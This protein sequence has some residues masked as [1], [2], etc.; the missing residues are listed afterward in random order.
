MTDITLPLGDGRFRVDPVDLPPSL[1]GRGLLGMVAGNGFGPRDQRRKAARPDV[2]TL[3]LPPIP[4]D[5]LL[6]GPVR[7]D[8]H[9]AA[10]GDSD[11][12][13]V[14][15][16]CIEK[17]DGRLINL[18]EGV[19]KA[20]PDASQVTVPLGDVCFEPAGDERVMAL[21]SGGAIPR[22]APP[23]SAATQTVLPDSSVT[24][25]MSDGASRGH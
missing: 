23:Q 11:R 19:T 22:W 17:S 21:V 24:I 6:A 16:L 13:W 9:T 25:T 14:V 1:G 12:L 8:L 4:A 18:C 5:S 7:A 10:G 3:P 2:L 20:P 15:D